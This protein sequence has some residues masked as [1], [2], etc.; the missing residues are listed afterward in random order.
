MPGQGVS[1][2]N[3]VD[4]LAVA[5][6]QPVIHDRDR[7]IQN[8]GRNVRRSDPL[9][10]QFALRRGTGTPAHGITDREDAENDRSPAWLFLREELRLGETEED[11]PHRQNDQRIMHFLQLPK[12]RQCAAFCDLHWR[13][14]EPGIRP[15]LVR[16][17]QRLPREL[18]HF[19]I[20]N[21]KHKC[22]AR[23]KNRVKEYFFHG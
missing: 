8:S 10:D 21:Q 7:G 12:V 13:F 23:P 19:Q 18:G 2:S 22:R 3:W 14:P 4:E 11:W 17:G 16:P 9:Q 5:P 15:P 6:L 20:P 1:N